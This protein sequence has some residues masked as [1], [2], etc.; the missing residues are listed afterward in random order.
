[1][2]R[3]GRRT[4]GIAVVCLAVV[5]ATLVCAASARAGGVMRSALDRPDAAPPPFLTLGLSVGDTRAVGGL[6]PGVSGGLVLGPAAGAEIFPPLYD[7]NLGLV[8]QGEYRSVARGRD[9]V[10]AGLVARRYFSDVRRDAPARTAF[11]GLGLDVAQISYPAA[12]AADTSAA[13]AAAGE[14]RNYSGVLECGWELRP[15]PGALIVAL[16]RWRRFDYSGFDYSGWSCH[17]QA[18]IPIPW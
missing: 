4:P 8:L 14:V 10:A 17:L 5:G 1:V 13:G 7:L 11:V 18:G 15:A 16:V 3:R 6:R 12:A 9:L 2:K